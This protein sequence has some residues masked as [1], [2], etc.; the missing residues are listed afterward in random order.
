MLYGVDVHAR[1]Q[2]G[3]DIALLAR[4]GYSFLATKATEGLGVVSV[5]GFTAAQFTT[6]MLTW[7]AQTRDAGMIPGLYHYLRA[8]DGAAQCD[9]FMRIVER[10]GGPDG[11]LIQLDNEADAGWVSTQQWAARWERLTGGHPWLMYTG[12]WW[13]GPRGWPGATLTP[14]LWHSHYLSADAD[15][16]PD[17]P[18]AFAARIPASWWTP[19][20]GGWTR[21]TILQFTSRGDAG[22]LGNNMDLNATHLTREQLLTLTRPGDTMPTAEE[23]KS[24]ILADGGVQQLLYRVEAALSQRDPIATIGQPN[25]LAQRLASL[26]AEVA[27]VKAAQ[28]TLDA[29]LDQILAAL[30]T[31]DPAVR[32]VVADALEAGAAA[33]RGGA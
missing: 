28:A 22:S 12:S 4:Q 32:E 25:V 10:A 20:Y 2:A 21:A 3:L 11:M 5:E 23:I 24:A 9:A 7:V 17:D 6:R 26:R 13:W 27:T 14:H 29:K 33:A 30:G 18:A 8:Q 19:G 1:Y 31:A 16:I 15:T